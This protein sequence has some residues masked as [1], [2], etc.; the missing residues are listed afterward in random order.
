MTGNFDP[1]NRWHSG[2]TGPGMMAASL[3]R[4][5]RDNGFHVDGKPG[6]LHHFNWANQAR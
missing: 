2:Q 5:L 4:N 1:G 3:C 6:E